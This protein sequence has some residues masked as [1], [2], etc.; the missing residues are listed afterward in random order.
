MPED[1]VTEGQK[2]HG[3][4]GITSQRATAKPLGSAELT[5][6][7]ASA[8]RFRWRIAPRAATCK[9]DFISS[10]DVHDVRLEDPCRARRGRERPLGV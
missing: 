9:K 1:F 4:E 7:P 5:D 8:A 2:L 10:R 6:V 3:P